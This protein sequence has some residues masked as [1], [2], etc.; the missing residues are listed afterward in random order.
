MGKRPARSRQRRPVRCAD[1]GLTLCVGPHPIWGATTRLLARGFPR[2][3]WLFMCLHGRRRAGD[4]ATRGEGGAMSIRWQRS[5]QYP[6]SIEGPSPRQDAPSDERILCCWV[7][8][9]HLGFALEFQGN[10]YASPE[11][12]AENHPETAAALQ[13]L[14]GPP[15]SDAAVEVDYARWWKGE[16]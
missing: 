14:V 2:G 9:R 1:C 5:I 10:L 7:G 6:G 13:Q 12:L 4:R 11:G 3:V 16:L 8:S 15:P